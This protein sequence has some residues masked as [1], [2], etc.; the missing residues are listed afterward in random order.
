VI[1]ASF[2]SH[3]LAKRRVIVPSVAAALG[4]FVLL[5]GLGSALDGAL[6]TLRDE[7]RSRPASGEVHIVEIDSRSLNRIHK[8]PLPRGVHAAAIDRLREAGARVIGFDVDFSSLSDAAEDSKLAAALA[9]AGG[10]VILPTFRQS[11]GSGSS[12]STE[13]IPVKAFAEKAFLGSVNVSPDSDGYVRQMLLGVATMGVA[14]PSLPSL[15]SESRAEIDRSFDIDYAIEPATIPRHSLVDLVSGKVPVAE[16]KGKRV[17]VGATAI[18][19]G[20]RYA[21]PRHGVLPGV[22]IQALAAETL[23]EGPVPESWSGLIPLI[24]MTIVVWAAVRATSKPLQ[25]AILGGGTIALLLLPLA[26]ESLFA[27]SIQ[28]APALAAAWAAALLG[29]AAM[30]IERDRDNAQADPDTG[31]PNLKA[32]EANAQAMEATNAVVARIDRFAAIAASLGPVASARLILRVA[33]RLKLA[34]GQRQIYRTDD[35]TLAWLEPLEDEESLDDRIE[36]VNALMRAP[37]E[38]DRLV[39][40]ALSFGAAGG[41]GSEAKQLVANAALAAVNAWQH[42]RNWEKFSDADCEQTSWQLSLLGELDAAMAS[43]QLWNAYQAKLDIETGR[44]VAA[45]ALVR[46]DHPDRG[47]ILPDNFIPLVEENGRARDLTTHVLEQALDDAL[48]WREKGFPIGVAVNVSASLL[49]DHG[50]IEQVGRIIQGSQ[51]PSNGV[52]IEV[53]ET[54]AMQD[55]ERAIRA[56][57]SWRKLGVSISIDDYGTGQSSLAYL[58]KLPA[59][60]LKI[61]KSFVQT[62]SRDPRNAIMVRSTIALAHELGMTVVAEGVEDA[63]C[64]QLLADMGCDTAQG[65][66]IGRPICADAMTEL[67]GER[68][69]RAA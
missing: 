18:E 35:A 52:T 19:M 59:N 20:D 42:D 27:V 36:A 38:A 3:L 21:V 22:V 1:K 39:D 58:Q 55:S 46:W 15:L 8:W 29:A 51:L 23:L 41:S 61:D 26:T 24:L 4:A 13:N 44:I 7:L 12:E 62:L 45:E 54:A 2:A 17:V 33:D 37:I 50:F 69:K 49:T 10:S 5:T 66:Y 11:A 9:R 67:L 47:M 48:A 14:R 68:E 60:E 64:L 57:E 53:T 28:I 16:L 40:V 65:F 63:E 30:F 43:G 25:A 32:L 56:L 34:N 6:R 31:L